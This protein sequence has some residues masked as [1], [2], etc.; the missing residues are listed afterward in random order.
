MD[1]GMSRFTAT[2]V[3]MPD[4]FTLARSSVPAGPCLRI[5]PI[6]PSLTASSPALVFWRMEKF[7]YTAKVERL[8]STQEPTTASRSQSKAMATAIPRL[9]RHGNTGGKSLVRTISRCAHEDGRRR[10]HCHNDG[11]KSRAILAQAG[12]ALADERY[13]E[14][15]RPVSNALVLAVKT[16][17]HT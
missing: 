12:E 1:S 4:Y 5:G 8:D 9:R 15:G 3:L 14:G 16:P 6:M 2:R 17:N 10:R 7:R 13:F 11:G